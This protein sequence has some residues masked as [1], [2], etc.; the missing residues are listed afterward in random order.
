MTTRVPSGQFMALSST[1]C[2]SRYVPPTVFSIVFMF[3]LPN[4][5]EARY[6]VSRGWVAA[7]AIFIEALTRSGLRIGPLCQPQ[8]LVNVLNTGCQRNR[9]HL[10]VSMR[11]NTRI[12]PCE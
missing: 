12:F 5:H 1:M 9:S 6:I 2:P 7:Y 11:G 4:R 8:N 3:Y 10:E